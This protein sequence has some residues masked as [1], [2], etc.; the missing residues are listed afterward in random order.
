MPL[1][2]FNM[3]RFAFTALIAFAFT[4]QPVF[5]DNWAV[6]IAGSNTYD[7]YRHQSDVCHAYQT[8][9]KN[10]IKADNI[11]TFI[12]DDVA[13]NVD[14]PYPGQIFNHPSTGKGT[15]VYANCKKS[16]TGKDVSSVNF[17]NVLRGNTTAMAGIGSGEVLKSNSSDNVFIAYHDHG[18]FQI[19]AMPDSSDYLY[20]TDLNDTLNYMYENHMYQRLVLYIEA[21]QSGSMFDGIISDKIN[22][23]VTTASGPQEDSWGWFCPGGGAAPQDPGSVVNG[24]DLGSCLGDLYSI[25]WLQNTDAN[26]TYQSLESQYNTVANQTFLSHVM[27]YGDL[28]FTKTASVGSFLGS[29][30]KQ[31]QKQKQKQQFRS[32][33]LYLPTKNPLGPRDASFFSLVYRWYNSNTFD[34]SWFVKSTSIL[35]ELRKRAIWEKTMFAFSPINELVYPINMTCYRSV[36]SNLP[37]TECGPYRDWTL[38]FSQYIAPLCNSLT[39]DEILTH[40]TPLCT[41][42]AI[43][44]NRTIVDAILY[45][46]YNESSSAINLFTE[47]ISLV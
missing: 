29:N 46:M 41:K 43:E 37:R 13:Q 6:L 21:C 34:N 18:G 30:K 1:I 5:S 23:Y 31:K 3:S 22:T 16:Y 2:I 7:N 33:N 32:Q 14:N 26:G 19:L 36:N 42:A 38:Q 9:R 10:G 24:K 25:V 47:L 45:K 28:S 35:I 4:S 8:L 15:D 40:I 12:Y 20:A 44:V 17:L 27:Q 11:I 39:A